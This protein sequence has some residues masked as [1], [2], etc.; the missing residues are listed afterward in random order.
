MEKCRIS[1]VKNI[2]SNNQYKKYI[3]FDSKDII[4]IR[5]M[6][7]YFLKEN[8]YIDGFA[9]EFP[10]CADVYLFNKRIMLINDIDREKSLIFSC[11]KCNCFTELNTIVLDCDEN[12]DA[13]VLVNENECFAIQ[14]V[15]WMREIIKNNKI[16]IYSISDRSRE[17]ARIY[18]LLDFRI[19]GYISDELSE[20]QE[21][22]SVITIE[23]LIYEED[24]FLLLNREQYQSNAERLSDLG[25]AMF[26]NLAIDNPF[27]TWYLGIGNQVLDINLGHSFLGSQGMCGF[28]I[29][30]DNSD[31]DYKIAV[32]GGSTTDGTLFPFKSW[33]EFLLEKMEKLKVTIFNGGVV[34]YTSTQELVKLLRDLLY[35]APDMVIVYDGFN[36]IA[37]KEGQNPFDFPDI[38]RAMEFVDENKDK[39]WL[40][41]FAENAAPYTGICPGEDKFSIW[42]NNIKRMKGICESEGIKF[43]AFH[44]PIL[45]SKPDLTKEEKGLLWSTWRINDC[46][47]WANIFRE[48]VK[49]VTTACDYIYD[50]SDIFDH[51]T[52][53]YMEDCHVYEKGN[54]IIA[55]AV[56]R[57]ICDKMQLQEYCNT[58]RQ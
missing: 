41:L 26:E 24:F 18:E 30:G 5:K 3:W 33:P 25:I 57:I 40:D 11:K 8:I 28:E 31:D 49:A 12:I 16:F 38:H 2:C 23:E 19:G 34:G 35:L 9:T 44:Q 21:D 46:Y 55:D 15:G 36:D 47:K 45:Y 4:R 52:N 51:E 29:L 32:L 1:D 27:G 39:I 14:N 42:V 43:L 56:Y 37:F 22:K 6:M 10:E 20:N 48:K 54:N 13:N 53:V 50:L 17:L 7:E 58:D